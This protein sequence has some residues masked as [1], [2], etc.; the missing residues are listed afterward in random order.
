MTTKYITVD[1][2]STEGGKGS[3]DTSTLSTIFH[4]S[5][6]GKGILKDNGLVGDQNPLRYAFEVLCQRGVT[7]EDLDG[8]EAQ[9]TY[10]PNGFSRDYWQNEEDTGKVPVVR[11]NDPDSIGKGL[12]VTPYVPN[13]ASSP[14]CLYVNQ[15]AMP[16]E[17]V[18]LSPLSRP[19]AYGSGAN[20]TR[21]HRLVSRLTIGSGRIGAYRLGSSVSASGEQE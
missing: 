2:V 21:R 8:A 9:N 11:S 15:P 4:Q 17:S 10:A 12:P 18:N 3:A 19:P 5:P 6:I 7:P 14:S 1:P 13:L 20:A 16:N